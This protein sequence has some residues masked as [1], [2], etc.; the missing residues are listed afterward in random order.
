MEIV[1]DRLTTKSTLRVVEVPTP[2]TPEQQAMNMYAQNQRAYIGHEHNT[3][4]I[5]N[6]WANKVKAVSQSVDTISPNYYI[7]VPSPCQLQIES[8]GWQQGDY[9][10]I[11][12]G[13]NIS[14]TN[15]VQILTPLGYKFE[16][17]STDCI[18]DVGNNCLT[19]RLIGE[20]FVLIA[21]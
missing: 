4:C 7:F 17:D 9:F 21:R 3:F 15:Y 8:Q 12:L 6:G 2:P 16:D 19:F 11:K 1:R 13:P 20:Y 18:L 5:S 10:L 14:E